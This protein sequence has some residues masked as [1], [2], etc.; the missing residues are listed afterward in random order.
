MASA[1]LPWRIE[2]GQTTANANGR[3]T[4]DTASARRLPLHHCLRTSFASP[5]ARFSK[6]PV[7]LCDLTGEER[8][9]TP[10]YTTKALHHY[11]TATSSS[12][13]NMNNFEPQLSRRSSME[14]RNGGTHNAAQGNGMPV[15]R[16]SNTRAPSGPFP[17]STRDYA[18][19]GAFVGARSPPKT[20]SRHMKKDEWNS[21]S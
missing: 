8:A 3:V 13:S 21:V 14:Y 19:A 15:T 1:V 20:K 4:L 10:N 5:Y 17:M 2:S 18:N 9:E 16:S 11:P 7:L 12:L 6:S